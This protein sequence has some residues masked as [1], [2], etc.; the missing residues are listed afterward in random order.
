MDFED[1]IACQI[2]PAG[3]GSFAL[4]RGHGSSTLLSHCCRVAVQPGARLVRHEMILQREADTL[5]LGPFGIGSGYRENIRQ[6]FL[7]P[8]HLPIGAFREHPFIST[9]R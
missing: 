6:D 8:P 5:R 7:H 1:D 3:G 4:A 2:P 9:Q